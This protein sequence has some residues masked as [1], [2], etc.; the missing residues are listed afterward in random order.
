MHLTHF[1]AAKRGGVNAKGFLGYTESD[2][3][4]FCDEVLRVRDGE[5]PYFDPLVGEF[6]IATHYHSN[7]ATARKKTFSD[8]WHAAS[9]R[10]RGDGE[11]WKFEPNYLTILSEKM[12]SRGGVTTRI[13]LYD[14]CAWLYRAR[15]FPDNISLTQVRDTFVSEFHFTTSE[16]AKLFGETQL[17][18][19]R[20]TTVGYFTSTPPSPA[21]IEILVRDP[22][23]F[24][25]S[26]AIAAA[27]ATEGRSPVQPENLLDLLVRGRG[28][29]I[30]QGPPGTSK[31]HLALQTA[32]LLLLSKNA[33]DSKFD[34][35]QVR[36]P[37][38]SLD[39]L[40]KR[41]AAT[42][43]WCL[44]QFH[45]S[46][47]YDDFV[48]GISPV[49]Q[50]GVPTFEL[51]DRLF[52]RLC[53]LAARIKKPVILI[54]DEV[55]RSD[56]SK[57]LGELIFG[58]EYRD[59]PILLQHRLAEGTL[60]VPRN[61]LLIATMNTADRSIASLD[62]A[63]RR[64]FDFVDCLPDRTVIAAVQGDSVVG[65]NALTI[66]DAVDGLLRENPYQSVGH[67]FFLSTDPEVLARNVV[68]QV[69]PLLAEY[70]REGILGD[71]DRLVLPDWPGATG[72]IFR[73][74]RPF[75]LAENVRDWLNAEH[76][77]PS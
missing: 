68:F 56:L 42:G 76:V 13:P 24:D 28:Q 11:E 51:Q 61:L 44:V 54:I 46:Y 53:Q 36:D 6:R 55:N 57:V 33:S 67:T 31:T 7:V 10:T 23:A 63:I 3:Q 19:T 65:R 34:E 17:D 26:E 71:T 59:R 32:K 74:E 75:E 16:A 12:L 40:A 50:N 4:R 43:T 49:I 70:R 22:A 39:D 2:D 62:L 1:L 35:L 9:Y 20:E 72:L 38:G 18:G 73:H 64:R 45:P 60:S 58:L 47:T 21:L 8:K 77:I 66:Y 27:A 29:L 25:L 48:R 69:L 41:F 14:L 37:G 5:Y 30:L 15:A 52:A